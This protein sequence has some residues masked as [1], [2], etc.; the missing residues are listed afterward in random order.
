MGNCQVLS[1]EVTSRQQVP[2]NRK[3]VWGPSPGA[4]DPIF[5]GKT[6]DLF[7]VITVCQLSVLQCHPYLFSPEKN[8][9]LFNFFAHHRR[10]YSFHSFTRVSPIIYGM[11]KICRCSCGSPFLWGPC[12][13]K[14]AE[15]A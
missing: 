12:L 10:F 7:L 2:S 14:H 9:D 6:G 15:H 13:A 5:P 3:N 1:Q 11:Q 4:A 8:G